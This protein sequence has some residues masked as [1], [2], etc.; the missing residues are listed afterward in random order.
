[1]S[2]FYTTYQPYWDDPR[3]HHVVCFIT[4]KSCCTQFSWVVNKLFSSKIMQPNDYVYGWYNNID[5]CL[6]SVRHLLLDVGVKSLLRDLAQVCLCA[7]VNRFFS[8]ELTTAAYKND[9]TYLFFEM[10]FSVL[11]LIEWYQFSLQCNESKYFCY[12]QISWK[13]NK[14]TRFKCTLQCL[15]AVIFV[16]ALNSKWC[17]S[18]S[19]LF[20]NF[21]SFN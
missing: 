11:F 12:K 17:M 16:G 19:F 15:L 10:F 1:M 8:V 21:L 14:R 20:F 4:S 6:C 18:I 2:N 9:S 5:L 13:L 7:C 3:L